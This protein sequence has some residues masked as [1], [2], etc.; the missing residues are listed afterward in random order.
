MRFTSALPLAA[1]VWLSCT[2]TAFAEDGSKLIT[3]YNCLG[4]HA[5]DKRIVGPSYKEVAA[6]Y[7]NQK[8]AEAL[9]MKEIGSGVQGKWGSPIPMPPQQISD[10]DL[11]PIVRW[12]LQQK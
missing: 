8:Q 10:Q 11:R 3:K 9:L 6:R 12:I 1:L 4:C 5:V 7:R 2:S